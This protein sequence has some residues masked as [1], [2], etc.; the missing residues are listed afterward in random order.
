MARDKGGWIFA[1]L[2]CKYSLFSQ[3]SI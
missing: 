1:L 3:V 2:L